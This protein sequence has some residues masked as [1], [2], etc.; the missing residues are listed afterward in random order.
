MLDAW[1]DYDV[2]LY[3]FAHKGSHRQK[4]ISDRVESAEADPDDPNH[5]AGRTFEAVRDEQCGDHRGDQLAYH[6]GI[7]D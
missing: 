5:L 7:F 1:T 3:V 6:Q 2:C 4:I